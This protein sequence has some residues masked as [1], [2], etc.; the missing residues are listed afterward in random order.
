MLPTLL[1]GLDAQCWN[2]EDEREFG[3]WV[4]RER[5]ECLLREVGFTEVSSCGARSSCSRWM[6]TQDID[7]LQWVEVALADEVGMAGSQLLLRSIARPR[8]PVEW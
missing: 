1:W 4:G 5:W 6:G 8:P 3:L 7:S 2:F